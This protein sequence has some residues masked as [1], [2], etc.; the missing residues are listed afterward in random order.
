M[1]YRAI[2]SIFIGQQILNFLTLNC[3]NYYILSDRKLLI[4]VALDQ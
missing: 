4:V 3:K 1:V 2:L